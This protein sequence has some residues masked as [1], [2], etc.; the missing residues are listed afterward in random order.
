MVSPRQDLPDT[1]I[2]GSH[3]TVTASEYQTCSFIVYLFHFTCLFDIL[4]RWAHQVVPGN[5]VISFSL[6][7]V[8]RCLREV[9]LFP[10]KCQIFWKNTQKTQPLTSKTSLLITLNIEDGQI[11]K[12]HF[13][14][15]VSVHQ[16]S[17]RPHLSE[18]GSLSVIRCHCC[19]ERCGVSCLKS[20]LRASPWLLY[21]PP[22]TCSYPWWSIGASYRLKHTW[23]P[24]KRWD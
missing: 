19:L 1:T 6:I 4:S 8:S 10:S 17:L 3:D 11:E 15:F 21:W 22:I 2:K 13:R 14:F 24:V 18:A 12:N 20:A 23:S 16:V 7:S 5:H 9:M